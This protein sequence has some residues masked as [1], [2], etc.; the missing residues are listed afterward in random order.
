M[1][2]PE[3]LSRG[4]EQ[5]AAR[6]ID[7]MSRLYYLSRA[8]HVVAELGV[9]D[10][11]GDDTVDLATVAEATGANAV[12]LRR[13]LRFLSSYRI[14]EET[15]PDRFRNTELSS[16]LRDDHP[17]SVRANL[18]RFGSFWWTAVGELEHTLRSGERFS[19]CSRCAV[20]SIFEKQRGRPTKPENGEK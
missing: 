4:A 13:L 11:L 5:S 8:I 6:L 17:Q 16:V 3:L 2:K 9:A 7:E 19:A 1:Q 12:T 20:F 18:Q 10:K 15:L 14:F